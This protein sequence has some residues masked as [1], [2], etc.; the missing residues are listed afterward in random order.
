M[1]D[2]D[3]LFAAVK[4]SN[5]KAISESGYFEPDSY[6]EEEIVYCFTGLVAEDFIN[7]NFNE[8]DEVILVVIDPL[9]IESPIKKVKIDDLDFIAI[10]GTFSLDSIIDKIRLQKDKNGKF[11]VRVKH[12]D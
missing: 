2:I 7:R 8:V 10:Q 11:N 4:P 1:L 5:W 6:K 3:L 9:R 12:F